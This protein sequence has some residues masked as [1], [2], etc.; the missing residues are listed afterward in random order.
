LADTFVGPL[1]PLLTCV[2]A[3]KPRIGQSFRSASTIPG[4]LM[5]DTLKSKIHQLLEQHRLMT[6]ATN[7]P[8]GW[9]QATR[10]DT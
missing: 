2:K 1:R 4:G 9:P 8:D 6:V 7:R 3:V 10:L 5:D